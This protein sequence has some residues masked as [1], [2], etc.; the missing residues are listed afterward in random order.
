[1]SGESRRSTAYG[2]AAGKTAEK[3]GRH[4]NIPIFIPHLGCPNDCVFC[5]QRKISG[6]VAY[7]RC[8]VKS[9]IGQALSTVE[10]GAVCEIAFFGGS[11]TGIDRDEMI[12]LL[13]AAKE[14]IDAGQ[15][16]SI[17]LS[18][19]PDYISEE[20]LT[21]LRDYGVKTVE[22]GIQSMDDT[23]LAAC[24]RGHTAEQTREACRL[25]RTH[26]F[27]LVGQM[28]IGLPGADL[29]SEKMTARAICDMGAVAARLYP[30]VVLRDTALAEMQDYIP[31]TTEEAVCRSAEAV[32][33]FADRQVKVIRIGLCAADNLTEDGDVL[34]GGY[35]SALGEMVQSRIY[36]KR[37]M[38]ALSEAG[39]E[40]MT[41]KSLRISC[42]MGATSKVVGQKGAV[43]AKI[44]NEFKVRQIK[45]IE[46]EELKE[47][48]IRIEIF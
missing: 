43:R 38:A 37:L 8:A 40:N 30:T 12:Y 2:E 47:Y 17:R 29:Q 19:R 20:I 10:A 36:E 35:H 13:S 6:R 32:E 42:P 33:I 14:F 39:R 26:G 28:M 16:G 24:R 21:V 3:P 31:L 5:N 9:E 18:T 34:A 25:I 44:Q 45:I 11:F 23:V 41:D 7:D 15:V 48:N 27:D 22:L 4:V 1:M 46:K